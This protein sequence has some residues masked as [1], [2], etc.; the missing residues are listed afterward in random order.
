MFST[1]DGRFTR[2]LHAYALSP[3]LRVELA[4]SAS[5]SSEHVQAAAALPSDAR[6][7]ALAR[8][9]AAVRGVRSSSRPSRS[10]LEVFATRWDARTLAPSGVL[11][12][13]VEVPRCGTLMPATSRAG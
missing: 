9:L 3:G 1:N 10:A 6:L 12:R 8:E 2:H 13:S 11:L 7:R 5:S 4:D